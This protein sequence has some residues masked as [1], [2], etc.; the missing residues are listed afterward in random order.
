MDA[1]IKGSGYLSI[2]ISDRGSVVYI[3]NMNC[4]KL[5]RDG[6]VKDT[7][8]VDETF[9]VVQLLEYIENKIK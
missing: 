7:L 5:I 6:E 4:V 3:R 2:P 9:T 8:S 1:K